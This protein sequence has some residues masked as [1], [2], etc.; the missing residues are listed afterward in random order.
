MPKKDN[1]AHEAAAQYLSMLV[2]PGIRRIIEAIDLGDYYHALNEFQLFWPI[3]KWDDEDEHI[4]QFLAEIEEVKKRIKGSQG[5]DLE[6]RILNAN[7]MAQADTE[8][9]A[10]K[11]Y[12]YT[13]KR[14]HQSELFKMVFGAI[15]LAGDKFSGQEEN[16]PINPILSSRVE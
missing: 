9:I 1:P 8:E 11:F 14:M 12:Q 13:W 15:A 10:M 4:K 2:I 7:I 3:V 5:V 6:T 16:P